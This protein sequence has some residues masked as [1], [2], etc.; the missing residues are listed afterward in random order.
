MTKKKKNKRFRKRKKS[1]SLK[2]QQLQSELFKLL[3][4]KPDQG[5]TFRQLCKHLQLKDKPARDHFSSLLEKWLDQ[6]KLEIAKR[7]KYQL[8]R[9][10]SE[11]LEGRVDYV[12]REFAYIICEGLEDD[13]R[14]NGRKLKDAFHDD[15]VELKVYS[16]RGRTEGE[17]VRVVERARKEYV[18][19]LEK[20]SRSEFGFVIPDGRKMHHDFFIAPENL[21]DAKHNDKVLIEFLDWDKGSPNP[22]GK[23]TKVLGQAGENEAEIHAIMAE[24]GLPWDFDSRLIRKANEIEDGVTPE[25]IANRRDMRDIL[26]FTIDPYNAKDFDDAL[27][28][29]KLKNG[30]W[31][32]GV[33]IADVTHYV[34][35]RTLLEKEAAKRATSVYL[36]DRVVPMLPERLSTGLCSLRP[37]EE[38]LTFSVVF[39][40]DEDGKIYDKWFGRTVILSDRRFT[41][42]EAQER[43][44]T[45]E[46]DY[47]N[48]VNALNKI[49]KKLQAKRFK[50][51]SI[52]FETPEVKFKLDKDGKPIGVVQKVRKDA[53][54]LVE[55]FM[56]L[57]NKS[58]GE[59]VHNFR[60]GKDKN[61]MVYRVHD[62]PDP[63]RIMQLRQFA[64]KFGYDLNVDP[65]HL[66]DSLNKLTADSEG[67][68]EFRFLQSLAVR[69]MAKA[70]YDIAHEGHFGLSFPH[71]TH[72]TSPI[73]RYPDMMAHRLL[74][75]YLNGGAPPDKSRYDQLCKN[76]SEQEKRATEAERASIKFKQVEYISGFLGEEFEGMITG[77]TDWG[78]FV[79]I[80]ENG[81]EGLVRI[82]SIPG[83]YYEFDQRKQAVVGQRTKTTL[84]LGSKVLI[85]VEAVDLEKRTIDFTLIDTLP[86]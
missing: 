2:P 23:I 85:Q 86:E 77:V 67:K 63:D 78:I 76:A 48:E 19:R 39:E 44:E 31:E 59:F 30:H 22:S 17:V 8:K 33:H 47:A 21:G 60:G 24:Y 75:H 72:F 34:R 69:S 35:P 79:E 51:G 81:C 18:G 42:E 65:E 38:K 53:H 45:G 3:K 9:R 27:S 68:P 6:G 26:T 10:E 73:R 43:I 28:I 32:I 4:T 25:E 83:D 12:S 13:V 57:A 16:S 84:R 20:H 41:Y 70:R 46:G 82:D 54:K 7:G 36:V 71:Y 64:Q 55:D 74:Q 11:R 61:T 15:L 50:Y 37:N 80:A 29:Q 49:A 40:M 66:R 1:I 52:A 14:V 5:F 56:L 62:D 58:V